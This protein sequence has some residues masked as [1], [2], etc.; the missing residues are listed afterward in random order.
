VAAEELKSGEGNVLEWPTLASWTLA[1]QQWSAQ[2]A[3][4]AEDSGPV[5]IVVPEESAAWSW[6]RWRE[7][8]ETLSPLPAAGKKWAFVSSSQAVRDLLISSGANLCAPVV[9]ERE[10]GWKALTDF[11]PGTRP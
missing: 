7:Y 4:L 11:S 3:A 9:G 8:M 10:A 1:L 2:I 5:L 6:R